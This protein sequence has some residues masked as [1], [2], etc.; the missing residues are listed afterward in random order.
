MIEH[1]F[2]STSLGRLS[3]G[4]TGSGPP[5]LLWHSVFID[6]RSW[7]PIVDVLAGHRRVITIDAPGHGESAKF[8][9]DYTLEDCAAAAGEA[10]DRLG[11]TEP[12]DWVGNAWGGHVGIVLAASQPARL[13]SLTTIG[14]PVHALSTRE[15]WLQVIPIALMYRVVGP[16]G[17][18]S[19][20]VSDALLGPEAVAAEPDRATMIMESFRR[21]PQAVIVREIRSVMLGR[22]DLSDRL[23]GIATPTLMLAAS[24]DVAGWTPAVAEAVVA[25]MPNAQVGAVSGTG[26]VSPLLLDHDILEKRIIKFWD[27][28]G[29]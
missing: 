25:K 3:I 23:P 16:N 24:D 4:Q 2:V 22:P 12:V 19:K 18:I 13:R 28:V 5:A 6:S 9:R 14:T 17:F 7:G 29:H 15:R 11:I 1:D 21:T 8:D 26:H 10:L 20:A 27:S